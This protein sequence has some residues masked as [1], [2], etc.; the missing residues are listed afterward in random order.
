LTTT[1]PDLFIGHFARLARRN[2]VKK[3]LPLIGGLVAIT[4]TLLLPTFDASAAPTTNVSKTVTTSAAAPGFVNPAFQ[5]VW[6][7]T[8]Q[9][10]DVGA[11]PRSYLWGPSVQSSNGLFAE[12]YDDSPNNYRLVQ[13][14]DKTRME[15]NNR[16]ADPNYDFY[17]S[18]GLL[19]VELV[20]G[21]QQDGNSRF[22]FK[23]PANVPIAGDPLNNDN[24]P[25]YASLTNVASIDQ[26]NPKSKAAPN[27][28]GQKVTASIDKAGNVNT[29]GNS[30][31]AAG[32]DIAFYEGT[33][34]HNIPRAL[35]DYLN[36]VGPTLA[37]DGKTVINGG[38]VFN[39]ISAMG[40]PITEPYWTH[41][42]VAGVDKEVLV[43][44]FQRRVLTY[45]PSNPSGFQVEMGNVGQHYFRWRYPSGFKNYVP[46]KDVPLK[47]PSISYGINAHMFYVDRQQVVSWLKETNVRWVRQQISW[48]DIEVNGQPGVFIWDELDKIVDSLYL[49]GFHIMLSPVG[50]PDMYK[51]ANSKL[52]V[53]TNN[54]G[55]F[56]GELSKRYQGKVDAYEIW[57]EQNLASEVGAP[58]QPNR[59]VAMLA[60]GSGAVKAN[61]PY[62]F[63]VLGALSP[64]G[65]SDPNIVIDDVEYLKQLYD[66]NNGEIRKNNYYDAV[67]VHPGS[68]CNPPDSLYPSQTVST[69]VCNGWKDHASFYF[70]RIEGIRQVMVDKGDEGR[71]MMLTEFG[72][73]S[74]P[75]PAPG[76]E[77]ASQVSEQQ[78]A[79]YIK[80]AF[81]KAQ[82]DYPYMGVMML[83]QLNFALP[84]VTPNANDEKVA[85]GILR[86][87]GTKRPS[88]FALADMAKTAKN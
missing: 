68:N 60:K 12:F 77:Y 81:Q 73:S 86:R 16:Y 51:A 74:T 28:T 56:M 23:T 22:S 35:F 47:V 54:F 20:S 6:L 32:S 40:L 30:G 4:L 36:L 84:S 1:E 5:K 46:P 34:G 65:F 50:T 83:W 17:V 53:D 19:V 78:Q 69:G 49:N 27:R 15:I 59:Y 21:A 25:T 29:N 45:T 11:T 44:A 63:V 13:Y 79:D 61:D 26:A 14:F 3:R 10:V 82:S 7:T 33:L 75:N 70:R 39:W 37:Q 71:Q 31:N 67:G 38:K 66:Y 57:N 85:W 2:F 76:Y 52:P 64:A 9:L 18:N 42:V 87:D 43:Q 24:S 41:A 80:R 62:A 8:D 88:F 58:I 72:W 48:R 55:R